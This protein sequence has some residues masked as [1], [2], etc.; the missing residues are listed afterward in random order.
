MKKKWVKAAIALCFA[1][2]LMFS[3]SLFASA[4]EE[5]TTSIGGHSLSLSTNME[6]VYFANF[7]NVPDGAE[8]GVV[9]SDTPTVDYSSRKLTA[10]NE[11][12]TN[13]GLVYYKYKLSLAAKELSK[14]C[15]AKSYIKVGDTVYYGALDKYSVVQYAYNKRNETDPG[16][17]MISLKQLVDDVL[18]YGA[19]AQLYL[20]YNT[21]RLANAIFYQVV[22]VNATLSDGTSKGMYLQ[23]D[24]LTITANDPA[25]MGSTACYSFDHW[26]N[27][28]GDNIGTD[29]PMMI[30]VGSADETI[31]AVF[32]EGHNVV[33]DPA[34]PAT[35]TEDGLTEGSHCS[36]CGEIIVAQQV[37]PAHHTLSDEWDYDGT[38]HWKTCSECGEHQETAEHTCI[39]MNGKMICSVCGY[40]QNSTLGL[41]FSLNSDG[42]SYTVTG[43]N[44]TTTN[45]D[46]VIPSQYRGKPVTAI[47]E[48]AFYDDSDYNT[49]ITS[50]QIPRSVTSIERRAF[51]SCTRLTTITF[52]AGMTLTN[53]EY[54]AFRNCPKL[55][56]LDLPKGLTTI[57]DN[58]CES[59]SALETVHIKG[60]VTTIGVNAFVNC[61]SLKTI[62]IPASVTS[63]GNAAFY[64]TRN[65]ET[66]YFG[67]Y[68]EGWNSIS[69]GTQNYSNILYAT[70]IYGDQRLQYSYREDTDSYIVGAGTTTET[71]IY[72]PETYNGK[73]VTMVASV[74]KLAVN[75]YMKDNVTYIYPNAF[76]RCGNLISVELSNNI[77]AI[78]E[79]TFD[80]CSSLPSITIPQNVNIIYNYAFRH[81]PALKT[82]YIKGPSPALASVYVNAFGGS[83]AVET[84][85]YGGTES[86]WQAIRSWTS[87]GGTDVNVIYNWTN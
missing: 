1:T 20:G 11:T 46:V 44:K 38:N 57:P 5:P 32:T 67:G 33:V 49:G 60:G 86:E 17:H 85:Y 54:G 83:T 35:C 61:Y 63:F 73:P 82:V 72:I 7:Q 26:E 78:D 37:I 28:N 18:D 58:L 75:V 4:E 8:C 41:I 51:S 36:V 48:D 30:T 23:G 76:Q 22:T 55:T 87:I 24:E 42:E 40:E 6:I 43:R 66:V 53:L 71:D 59:N 10:M 15:Y 16:S 31:T 68:E 62:T 2:V 14:D 52:E 64:E 9:Y 19:A 81:C 70:R 47:G 39:G 80:G 21:D 69:K 56:E 45:R 84:V 27:A 65:I 25:D 74:P 79:Y 29:N 77:T 13:N 3:I 50:V 34:V 12:I